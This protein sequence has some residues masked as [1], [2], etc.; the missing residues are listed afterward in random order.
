MVCLLPKM[1]IYK[2][3]CREMVKTDADEKVKLANAHERKKEKEKE[4][5]S[6]KNPGTV[7]PNTDSLLHSLATQL[8]T[9]YC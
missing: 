1:T 3:V 8:Q 5:S 7:K 6:F 4:Q 2:D 9:P